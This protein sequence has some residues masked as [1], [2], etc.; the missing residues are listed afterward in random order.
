MG[1]VPKMKMFFC[2]L[3]YKKAKCT[4][5]VQLAIT[6]FLHSAKQSMR[7]C[8]GDLRAESGNFKPLATLLKSNHGQLQYVTRQP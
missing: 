6:A 3:Q 2:S 4:Y 8:S 1:K 7:V 5:A